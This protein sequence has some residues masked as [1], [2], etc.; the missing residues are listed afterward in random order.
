MENRLKKMLPPGSMRNV[1]CLYIGSSCDEIHIVNVPSLPGVAMPSSHEQLDVFLWLP[2]VPHMCHSF[3]DISACRLTVLHRAFGAPLQDAVEFT[4]IFYDQ[5]A[6][7]VQEHPVNALVNIIAG[8]DLCMPWYKDILVVKSHAIMPR[9][10]NVSPE[11]KAT[12]SEI[13]KHLLMSGGIA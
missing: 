9:I 2:G 11:D 5:S 4:F 8:S 7:C 13:L 3:A 10:M 12:V 6:N 1:K